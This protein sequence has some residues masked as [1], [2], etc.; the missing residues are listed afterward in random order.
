[1]AD[2][3]SGFRMASGST[4]AALMSSSTAMSHEKVR[5]AEGTC[6]G[7]RLSFC[8]H[9]AVQWKDRAEH[10]RPFPLRET[11][12][13]AGL[14]DTLAW[15][16]S[17]LVEAVAHTPASCPLPPGLPEPKPKLTALANMSHCSHL[18]GE[19]EVWSS[20]ELAQGP[21][22]SKWESGIQTQGPVQA[23]CS[24]TRRLPP[25]GLC[26]SPENLQRHRVSSP[27]R[28]NTHQPALI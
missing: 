5:R 19:T 3:S 6:G 14:G 25:E 2:R 21:V 12:R 23:P 4:P 8:L 16:P 15:K 26:R 20:S 9:V 1:M 17:Q 27:L 13:Q 11:Q 7:G 10:S 18:T 24:E 28:A 22:A